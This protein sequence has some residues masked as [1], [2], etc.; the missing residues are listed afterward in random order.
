MLKERHLAA[1]TDK[2]ILQ[3]IPPRDLVSAMLVSKSWCFAAF[4]LLWQKPALSS[5]T[6]FADFIRIITSPSPLL[7]Y[8]STVRRL[9][10]NGFSRHLSDRLF[11]EIVAC[12]S[13]ERVTMP[14]ATNLSA[15]ALS[16]VFTSLKE[17]IAIDLSGVTAVDDSVVSVIASSCQRVQGLNLSKC[18]KVGDEGLLA[19]ARQ[20]KML[21][22]VRDRNTTVID[23]SDQ[24][25]GLHSLDRPVH[26]SAESVVPSI[27]GA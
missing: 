18:N 3:H 7:P 12:K 8:A 9:S 23:P 24:A 17:L 14:G 6:Q 2:Q 15:S 4:H 26:R 10:F 1:H 27:A 5:I 22:R 25:D 20:L 16:E 19:I 21:R 11:R 13:L